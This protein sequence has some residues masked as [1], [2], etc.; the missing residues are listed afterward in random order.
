MTSR[1]TISEDQSSLSSSKSQ[2]LLQKTKSLLSSIGDTPTA[3]YD[4]KQEA[5]GKKPKVDRYGNSIDD[6][7]FPQQTRGDNRRSWT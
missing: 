6:G 5:A 4:R 3:N 2:K 1:T 7:T